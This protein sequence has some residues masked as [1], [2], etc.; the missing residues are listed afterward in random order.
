[1]PLRQPFAP[2]PSLPRAVV[3]SSAAVSGAG[4]SAGSFAESEGI[5]SS[6]GASSVAAA[7][8]GA[9]AGSDVAAGV[10]FVS[11]ERVY[12]GLV[13]NIVANHGKGLNVA[14][15]KDLVED[16]CVVFGDDV[17][18][19]CSEHYGMSASVVEYLLLE[20]EKRSSRIA[21]VGTTQ[22]HLS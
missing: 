17:I 14:F 8:P 10:T 18:H 1:M 7:G 13:A 11:S 12:A 20:N 9:A 15:Y 22:G 16:G 3:V 21:A 5:M 19:H 2:D 4:S 6:A